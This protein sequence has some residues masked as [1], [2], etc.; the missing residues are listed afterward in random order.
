MSITGIM[1]TMIFSRTQKKWKVPVALLVVPAGEDLVRRKVTSP[2]HLGIKGGSNGG[3]LMG[4]MLT[5]RPDLWGG[6]VCQVPLLDMR[7]YHKLLAGASWQGEYGNP[8]LRVMVL[9]LR[10]DLSNTVFPLKS[11]KETSQRPSANNASTT[12]GSTL[13]A[14]TISCAVDSD[15]SLQRNPHSS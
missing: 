11:C 3:L 14:F 4:N 9:S 1:M 15:S 8:D 13:T 6:V 12:S 5:R 7:R 2:A 10:D